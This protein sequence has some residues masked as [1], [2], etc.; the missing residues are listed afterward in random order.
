MPSGITAARK[1]GA[2]P[3]LRRQWH[4]AR[5]GSQLPHLHGLP[6]SR[7]ADPGSWI[8]RSLGPAGD[9][10]VCLRFWRQ[11]KKVVVATT[12][13][14]GAAVSSSRIT[15]VQSVYMAESDKALP[16]SQRGVHL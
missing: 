8:E 6:G 4:V 13:A 14:S 7:E 9:Q 3:P 2:L 11:M 15:A 12:A 5:L 10:R 1:D 16:S